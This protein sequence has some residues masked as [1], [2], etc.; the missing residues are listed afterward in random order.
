M[1]TGGSVQTLFVQE[2]SLNWLAGDD[3]RIYDLI[4]IGQGHRAIPHRFWI[5]HKVWPMLALVQATGLVGPHFAFEPKLGKLLF[6]AF[7]QFCIPARIA[8]PARMPRG[9]HVPA[10]EDV[11]L[12]FRHRRTLSNLDL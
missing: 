2:Q 6:E 7:L 8:A 9:T 3:V 4:D 1:L 5:N 12:K 10:N 11:P